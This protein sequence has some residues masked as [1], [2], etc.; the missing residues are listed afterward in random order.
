MLEDLSDKQQRVLDY[1]RRQ[2]QD[3]SR[4]PTIREIGEEFGISSTNGVRYILGVLQRK[5]YLVRQAHLSRGIELT[6]KT[7][8]TEHT[9]K[10]PVKEIL[11]QVPLVGRVAAGEPLLAEQN[12]EGMIAVDPTFVRSEGTFALHVSGDSMMGAGIFDGDIV[13]ARQQADYSRGDVVVAVIGDEATVKY[14][15]PGNGIVRLEPAN[16]HYGPIVVER[17]TPGF[18]IAGKV[19]GLVRKM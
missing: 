1:I 5:G 3:T 12:L 16:P 13:F 10:R 15:Y 11:F 14:Y 7:L 9:Q 18:Y 2:V 6:A 8:R 19:V 17:S 4:P